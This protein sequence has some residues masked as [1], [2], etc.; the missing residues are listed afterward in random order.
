[1]LLLFCSLERNQFPTMG[2]IRQVLTWCE[3]GL[4]GRRERRQVASPHGDARSRTSLPS[5]PCPGRPPTGPPSGSGQLGPAGGSPTAPEIY[6]RSQSSTEF[7]MFWLL[8]V[9]VEL[10]NLEAG[11]LSSASV[12]WHE[13]TAHIWSQVSIL[14]P[15]S[16]HIVAYF[17]CMGQFGNSQS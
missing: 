15:V 13:H 12:H 3:A 5:P 11:V 16:D 9:V 4:H 6:T 10:K 14:V 1:M 2:L 17:A 7:K 8:G